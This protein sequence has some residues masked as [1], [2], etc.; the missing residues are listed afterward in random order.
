MAR[1]WLLY[2]HMKRLYS[3]LWRFVEW[4][5]FAERRCQRSL[6]LKSRVC[7]WLCASPSFRP[8]LPALVAAG[9]LLVALA[10]CAAPAIAARGGPDKPGLRRQPPPDPASGWAF[11]VDE[12]QAVRWRRGISGA[13]LQ[14]KAVAGAAK[15]TAVAAG[16][17]KGAP[18]SI[19]SV[20]ERGHGGRGHGRA[21]AR[22]AE[23]VPDGDVSGVVLSWE[24][25]TATWHPEASARIRQA[26]EVFSLHQRHIV[27]AQARAGDRNASVSIGPEV[28][29]RDDN[30]RS[31]AK[32]P[33]SPESA[34]GFGMRFHVGF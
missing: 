12:E 34:V 18:A 6:C 15:P 32:D 5:A 9:L 19:S 2:S 20:H 7:P 16:T 24:R 29:L 11:G 10:L 23:P 13:D 27:R 28:I 26:G 17:R 22:A 8:R 14:H 33:H 1:E 25:D 3:R 4:R 30:D 21:R 31:V